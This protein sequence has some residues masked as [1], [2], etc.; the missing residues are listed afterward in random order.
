MQRLAVLQM[1]SGIDPAVNAATIAQAATAASMGGATMLFTPE[2][3]VLIDR[4]RARAAPQVV[5]EAENP[6]LDSVRD[7]AARA[8]MWIALGSMAVLRE[9]GRWA[10]RSFVIDGSGA[11]VARYD[12]IHMFDVDLASGESWRESNAYAAGEGAVTVQTPLGKLG[13]TICYDLR[14]PALFEALGREACDIIAVPAAFTVPTG[15]AQRG[16]DQ[17]SQG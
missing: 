14:F 7:A 4:D 10:N 5:A 15:T 13:L 16:H 8:G 17:P 6:A 2:M 3:S 11:I 1:T 9:D 12:K